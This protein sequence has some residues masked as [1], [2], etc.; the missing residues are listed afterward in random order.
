M[1]VSVWPTELPRPTQQGYQATT[2]ETRRRRLAGG[3]LG[4]SRRF[5]SGP[6]IVNLTIECTRA[7]KAIFD[8]FF[9]QT[10]K[11]GSLPFWM[12]DPTS[13]GTV[14]LDDQ[15]APVLDQADQPI[16]MSARWLV[17]FGEELPIETNSGGRYVISFTVAVLP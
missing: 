1:S 12:P 8:A 6:R 9:E 2:A 4:F 14:L 5:S 16:L 15:F 10:T 13:D 11:G 7:L 17:L 3:P